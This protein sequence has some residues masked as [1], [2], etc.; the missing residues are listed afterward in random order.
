MSTFIDQDQDETSDHV[1]I[2]AAELLEVTG[3]KPDDILM[4]K[5]TAYAD[6]ALNWAQ[7]SESNDVNREETIRDFEDLQDITDDIR[8]GKL[9]IDDNGLVH[10]VD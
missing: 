1:E 5:H 2:T 3:T 4:H 7:E 6:T 9:R 8:E 10:D